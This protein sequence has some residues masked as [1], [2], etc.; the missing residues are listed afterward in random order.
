[1]KYIY[2]YIYIKPHCHKLFSEVCLAKRSA[3][4]APNLYIQYKNL[5]PHQYVSRQ[6]AQLTSQITMHI[7]Q[8]E[9][10]CHQSF[11]VRYFKH[12]SALLHCKRLQQ[13]FLLSSLNIQNATNF[14]SYCKTK[15]IVHIRTYTAEQN[16]Y[17]RGKVQ[18]YVQKF[19]SKNHLNSNRLFIS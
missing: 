12:A 11:T 1:M 4:Q 15:Q 3:R 18:V 6:S 14:L 17:I 16:L 5:W 9:C 7:S 19:N 2:E 10:G 13:T 8:I